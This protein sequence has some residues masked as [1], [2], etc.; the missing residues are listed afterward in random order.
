MDGLPT[1]LPSVITICIELKPTKAI[2]VIGVSE[3]YHCSAMIDG[4]QLEYSRKDELT[5]TYEL[6][7]LAM[8]RENPSIISLD[9][10]NWLSTSPSWME[11]VTR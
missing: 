11:R 9:H 2:L 10:L 7:L 6:I 3:G 4:L 5:P 8:A 1:Y